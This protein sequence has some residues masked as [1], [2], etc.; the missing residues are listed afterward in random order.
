MKFEIFIR[1]I[2]HISQG[3]D[4]VIVRAFDSHPKGHTTDMDCSNLCH[5]YLLE[6]GMTQNFGIA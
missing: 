2:S 6:V 3:S 5:A 4:H 1:V